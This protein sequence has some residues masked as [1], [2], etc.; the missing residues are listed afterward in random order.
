[1][2]ASRVLALVFPMVLVAGCTTNQRSSPATYSSVPGYGNQVISSPPPYGASP[3]AP[4]SYPP[5]TTP[6]A[7]YS[8]ASPGG[9]TDGEIVNR[10]EQAL[11]AQGLGTASQDIQV[12]AQNGNVTLAGS[13]PNE[14]Q[15]QLAE[16]TVRNVSGV[17]SVNDQ[18]QVQSAPANTG[19]NP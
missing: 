4:R 12:S 3:P 14:Q 7:V 17:V 2:K 13:V 11:N 8:Q 18:L 9:T 15:R 6:P 19:Q 10:A 16:T 1:M 5:G